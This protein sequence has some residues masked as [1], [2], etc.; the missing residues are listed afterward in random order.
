VID[1][2]LSVDTVAK[3]DISLSYGTAGLLIR[4][5]LAK[6][7][8]QKE[9]NQF[10]RRIIN[11]LPPTSGS[12]ISS[13]CKDMDHFNPVRNDNENTKLFIEALSGSD[14]TTREGGSSFA[15]WMCTGQ[16]NGTRDFARAHTMLFPNMDTCISTFA[17]ADACGETCINTRIWGKAPCS[18]MSLEVNN[19]F[20]IRDKFTPI[21][22]KAFQDEWINYLGHLAG[23]DPLSYTGA[24]PLWSDLVEWIIA[25]DI[26]CLRGYSL[27]VLQM[28]NNAA[29]QQ[30]CQHPTKYEMPEFLSKASKS[31]GKGKEEKGGIRG[32][33]I[34]GFGISNRKNRKKWIYAGFISFYDHLDAHLSEAD[35]VELHFGAIFVEHLLC[36]ISRFD[37]IFRN[38][39]N[40]SL[41]LESLGQI[42]QDNQGESWVQ[43]ANARNWMRFPIPLTPDR[44]ELIASI[45]AVTVRSFIVQDVQS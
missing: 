33:E 12:A 45:A 37:S 29:I 20:T 36:K 34:L 31:G 38:D 43:G 18:W 39:P 22:S 32:L 14:L 41:T 44:D 10:V 6:R 1:P 23:N 25:R 24:L 27:T 21:F 35:K 28:A 11:Q 8:N 5:I 9:C 42:A 13:N 40:T 15:A 3:A 30:L 4:E 2:T 26:N 17:S 7:R 19:K 16:G